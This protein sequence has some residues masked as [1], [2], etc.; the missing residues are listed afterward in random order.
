MDHVAP[1]RSPS[2]R[3]A[4][5]CTGNAHKL[6]ELAELL[7]E[8]RLEPLPDGTTLPPEIGKT[9]LDNAR[10]KAHAGAAMYP[11]RWVLADDSGLIVDAL[12]GEPGVH[13]ARFAGEGATDQD[14][15]RKLLRQLEPFTDVDLRTARFACV[16]VMVSPDGEET[17][18]TGF[19]EGTI[20]HEP[21]GDGGFGYDPVFVPEGHERTFAELGSEVKARLSHRAIAAREL[22]SRLL[23]RA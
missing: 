23:A 10:I 22:E 2:T 3:S 14:N 8:F 18:T 17:H 21:A 6:R 19:V 16:L 4:V 1:N 9:F 7:P 5:V 20:A 15:V 13:S 11:D 12:D